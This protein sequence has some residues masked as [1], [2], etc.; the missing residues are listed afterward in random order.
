[1]LLC[2]SGAFALVSEPPVV[3][4]RVIATSPHDA[5]AF[6]QGLLLSGGSFFESTGL[7]GRSSLREVTPRTG[8]VVRR[9]DLGKEY[10]AEGLAL[11]GDTLF[12]L[13]WQS[14]VAFSYDLKTFKSQGSFRYD[15]EGWGLCYDGARLV[16]SDGSGTLF[17]RDP[18][19]FALTGQVAVKLAGRDVTRLNEL[20]CVGEL[21]YANVWQTHTIL[22]IDPKSGEVLTQV[23]ASELA[24]EQPGADVLNGIAYD[25]AT[26]HFFLTGKLWSKVY[27][28]AFTFA[29]GQLGPTDAGLSPR[30]ASA[31]GAAPSVGSG[32]AKSSADGSSQG[33]AAQGG[34]TA[35]DGATDAP[36]TSK[37]S[38]SKP[39]TSKPSTS[40]PSRPTPSPS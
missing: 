21:V 5:S 29:P 23:D 24:R 16:M 37:P 26:Q 25:P 30:D 4:P 20:E 14:G 9:V 2:S 31:P 10:F 8:A 22:R 35:P 15:G 27:E 3:K 11:V 28:T 19:T 39:S 36:S 1:M 32:G 40:K 6:T 33:Q 17:F 18:K 12:Q 7:N 38:T 13:T 34:L